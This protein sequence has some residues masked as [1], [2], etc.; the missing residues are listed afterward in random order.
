MKAGD[1]LAKVLF[2]YGF[3]DSDELSQGKIICPFHEDINPSLIYDLSEGSWFCFGCYLKGDALDF[4]EHMM[5]YEN[6][7]TRHLMKEY[8]TILNSSK[9]NKI[10]IADRESRKHDYELE[11]I[12]AKNYYFSLTRTNWKNSYSQEELLI[13]DYMTERGFNAESMNCYGARYTYND[14]YP[15]VFPL[16]DNG[17]FRGY[18]CRAINN[19]EL[20]QR[21]KYLYNKGF[22]RETTLCGNYDRQKPVYVVEGYMDMLRLKTFGIENVVA[23][24]GWKISRTQVEKLINS[25]VTKVVCCL[26]NDKAGLKGFKEL[27][28][29]FDVLKFQ[30]KEGTKDPGE[31]SYEEFKRQLLITKKVAEIYRKADNE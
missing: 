13:I 1:R 11:L 27:C 26:D 29:H 31:M 19:P 8:Y 22:R 4:V 16:M 9:A 20:E 30:Y 10:K 12:R 28:K 5:E 17:N 25:G 14:S 3:I 6:K 18:V 21:R 24:L 23:I 7:D 15:L 2:Y